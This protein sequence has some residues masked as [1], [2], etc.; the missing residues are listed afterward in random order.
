MTIVP[1]KTSFNDDEGKLAL[2]GRRFLG[3]SLGVEECH[4]IS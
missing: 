3:W 2:L 1:A 4:V